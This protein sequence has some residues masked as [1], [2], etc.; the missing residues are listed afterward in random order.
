MV[1]RLVVPAMVLSFSKGSRAKEAPDEF[2][3]SQIIL[4]ADSDDQ[5]QRS[6]TLPRS[7]P[8]SSVLW[9]PDTGRGVYGELM[10]RM[11]R[12]TSTGGVLT[13]T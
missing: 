13:L 11:P 10:P 12:L 7:Q 6:A 3:Q 5:T 9:L 1:S 2:I 4:I 8:R